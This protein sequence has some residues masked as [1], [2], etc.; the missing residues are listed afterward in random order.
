[1]HSRAHSNLLAASLSLTDSCDKIIVLL[2]SASAANSV[3][4]LVFGQWVAC[5]RVVAWRKRVFAHLYYYARLSQGLEY[6]AFLRI[7]HPASCCAYVVFWK[8]PQ[9]MVSFC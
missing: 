6:V 5:D 7:A 1:M 4:N 3:A 2:S 8:N 9:H